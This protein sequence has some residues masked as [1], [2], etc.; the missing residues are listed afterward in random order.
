MIAVLLPVG[1]I[2]LT[3]GMILLVRDFVSDARDWSEEWVSE[4]RDW[5]K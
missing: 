4:L 2:V 3:A 1:S 5:K